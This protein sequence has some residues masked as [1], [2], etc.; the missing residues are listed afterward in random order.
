MRAEQRAVPRP[1]P[2]APTQSAVVAAALLLA[3]L[4]VL[5]YLPIFGGGFIWDDDKFLTQ[6]PLIKA[7]DGLWR[8]WFTTQAPDFW[9]LT[10]TTLWLEWRIWGMNA[11]GYHVTNVLLHAVE[12]VLLWSILRRLRIPGAYLGA[13]IFAVH[14]VNVETVAWITQRKNLMAMLFFLLSIRLFLEINPGEPRG[15]S[16][17]RHWA[18]FYSLSL[19]AFVLALLA[20]GSVA[21]LPIVLVGI[22]GWYRRIELRDLVRVAPYL[23]AA[24]VFS[25]I[26]V[27]L[28][29]HDYAQF[30]KVGFLDRALGAGAATWFYLGKALWPAKLSFV[31]P[32]WKIS[33]SDFHWWLPLIAAAAVTAVMGRICVRAGPTLARGGAFAWG[34]FL[35]MLLPVMGFTD[36]GF[37][38]FSLVA[39][40]YQHLALIGIAAFAAAALATWIRGSPGVWRPFSYGACVAIVGLLGTLT[41]LQNEVY[42]DAQML[43]TTTLELNPESSLAHNNLAILLSKNPSGIPEAIEHFE[44]AL[45]IDPEMSEAHY[46]LAMLLASMPDRRA[47]AISHCEAALRINP[48]FALAHVALGNLLASEP[49]RRSEAVQEYEEA[50]RLRPDLAEAHYDLANALASMPGRLPDAIEHYQKAVEINPNDENAENNLANAL[51]MT[52]GGQPEAIRHYERALQLNPSNIQA[53]NNLA[54][55]LAGIPGRVPEAVE[56]YENAIRLNPN[57]AQVHCNL[58]NALAGMP[59]RAPE[60][61]TQYEEALRLDPGLSEARASLSAL[62]SAPQ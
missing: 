60:A 3:G 38:K 59:G 34:Y 52:R 39:D 58:A 15:A 44:R 25:A 51:A 4:S 48:R 21:P 47:E 50:L 24:V 22:V 26:N 53:E 9:P 29:S 19:I 55:V 1:R 12:A 18:A 37:M 32:Q 28:Q 40:H 56:H 62:R 43:Y 57:I 30:R 2:P 36:V 6:N 41:F 27:A 31:Y 42:A 13:L 20:K 61:A 16:P 33:A 8:F 45:K 10:S 17:P 23:A 7:P 14:P 11:A 54:N 5:V 46:N 49:G 35:V